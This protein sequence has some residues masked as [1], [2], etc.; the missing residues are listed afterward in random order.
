[1]K[2]LLWPA[3]TLA[4]VLNGA[5][6]QV[7]SR[8][9][10]ATANDNKVELKAGSVAVRGS[11]NRDS[12][13]LFDISAGS[14]KLVAR[15][16]VGASVVGPPQSLAFAPDLSVLVVSAA[17]RIDPADAAKVI[18]GNS[19]SVIDLQVTPPAVV[20]TLAT[21]PAPAGV[22][23][24]PDG[25]LVL[26]TTRTDSAIN[27]F[28]LENKRLRPLGRIALPSGAVPAGV[29]FTP[30][31]KRALV[32]RDGDSLVTVL[33]IADGNARLAG[34]DFATGVRPYGVHI[35][36][37]GEW[38]IV[39]NVGRNQGDVDT[40][41]LVDMKAPFPRSIY[42][43]MVGRNVEGVAMSP[44]SRMVAAV[45]HDG[46]NRAPDWP[47]YKANGRVVLMKIEGGR[48][49]PFAEAPIG[50][51]SQAAAFSPDMKRL[52]V[53]NMVE[54]NLQVFAIGPNGIT[55]TGERVALPGGGAAMAI[56]AR[57]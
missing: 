34:R 11:D 22:A 33:D 19:V 10:L 47:M 3:M 4:C 15:I 36:P 49:T 35:S 26:V 46:S 54:R 42:H 53:Q 29:A 25:K 18:D 24:S 52:Y 48:L 20:Q 8:A 17:T 45:V 9:W 23:I 21:G 40:I 16:E 31:G 39:G 5:C 12:V 51:W 13:T 7:P 38:A 44:D 37:S 41:T 50:A 14:P 27:A 57:Q 28:A 55:D 43:A 30:D 32:T 56:G 1:M 2:K 6:A